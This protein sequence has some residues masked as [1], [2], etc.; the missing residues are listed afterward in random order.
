MFG[1]RNP[2]VAESD[3]P[4]YTPF[5]MLSMLEYQAWTKSE[6]MIPELMVTIPWI[7]WIGIN[8]VGVLVFRIVET[9]PEA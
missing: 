8:V 6:A 5:E 1:M 4:F 9:W 3:V 7:H 2:H